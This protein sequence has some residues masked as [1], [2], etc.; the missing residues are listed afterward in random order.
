MRSSVLSFSSLVLLGSYQVASARNCNPHKCTLDQC[1]R[2][3]D[4]YDS[5][6]RHRHRADCSSFL[7]TTVTPSTVTVTATSTPTVAVTDTDTVGFTVLTT[8]TE[9]L[10]VTLTSTDIIPTTVDVYQTTTVSPPAAGVTP[11]SEGEELLVVPPH[12]IIP[13]YASAC[14]AEGQYASACSCL[15][16]EPFTVFAPTPSTTVTVAATP[17]VTETNYVTVSVSTTEILTS[18]VTS[19]T[20]AVVSEPTTATQTVEATVTSTPCVPYP[21]NFVLYGYGP[22][23]TTFGVDACVGNPD[24]YPAINVATCDR[25]DTFSLDSAGHLV[26]PSSSFF[27]GPAIAA[28][29]TDSNL[30]VIR[31][32]TEENIADPDNNEIALT[33]QYDGFHLLCAAGDNNIFETDGTVVYLGSIS[34]DMVLQ[35]HLIGTEMSTCP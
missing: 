18:V 13:S 34:P 11:R 32:D 21:I 23:E 26:L 5:T 2:E 8:E 31:F 7:I 17:G 12:A 33:C 20:I 9:S 15:G 24:G 29:Q 25:I 27:S 28:I 19:T 16:V 6:A 14:T 3:V 4:D 1:Y 10:L 22:F 30:S 35:Y